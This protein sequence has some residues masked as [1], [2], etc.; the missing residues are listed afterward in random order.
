MER[1]LGACHIRSMSYTVLISSFTLGGKGISAHFLD[2]TF[3]N[4]ESAAAAGKRELRTASRRGSV[5]KF[6]V[7]DADGNVAFT[8]GPDRRH[9]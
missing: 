4:V 1:R 9:V 7:Q 5:S 8:S 3:V 2:A 6:Q